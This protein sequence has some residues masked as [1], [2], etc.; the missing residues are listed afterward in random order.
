MKINLFSKL[1][2]NVNVSKTAPATRQS[3]AEFQEVDCAIIRRFDD[4]KD[5]AAAQIDEDFV[6]LNNLYLAIE[7]GKVKITVYKANLLRTLISSIWPQ[8]DPM[9]EWWM[10]ELSDLPGY[11]NV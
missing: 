11:L 3:A 8:T 6:T 4:L 5:E 2:I 9:R 1:Q 10:N 7:S